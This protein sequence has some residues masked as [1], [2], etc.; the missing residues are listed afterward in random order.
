MEEAAATERAARKLSAGWEA[1]IGLAIEVLFPTWLLLQ[2][3]ERF[4]TE[5]PQTRIELIESVLSGTT[6]A[7]LQGRAQL[8]I[9]GIVPQGFVGEALMPIRFLLVANPSHALHQLGRPVT[10]QDL[11]SQRQLVVRESGSTRSNKARLEATQ[12]WTVSHM[13]TSIE[14]ASRGYGYGWYPEYLIRDE[15]DAGTLKPLA[16]REGGEILAQLYLVFADRDAA[17]PGTLRL[18]AIIREM[19]ESACT[20][21]RG[22][23]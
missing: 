19:V 18:A 21:E 8:A 12:R 17:G 13:R 14:A 4:G 5:S 20:K 16:L 10:M 22:R 6:E 9:A 11:R 7:L 3:L 23:Q 2:C 15:I 1:E